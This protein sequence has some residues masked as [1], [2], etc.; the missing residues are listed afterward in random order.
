MAGHTEIKIFTIQELIS[1]FSL[2]NVGKK[3]SIFDKTKLDWV[4]GVYIR[5]SQAIELQDQIIKF[6]DHDFASIMNNWS[7]VQ[8]LDFIDLYK[9]RTKTL[10]ELAQNIIE[11]HS[12]PKLEHDQAQ[13][14]VPDTTLA[15][16]EK[17]IT[18]LEQ[19]SDFSAHSL[20]TYAQLFCREHSIKLPTIAHPIRY[21]LTGK[22]ESP[23]IFHI[24]S[25]L[26]KEESIRRLANFVRVIHETTK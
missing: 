22:K 5:Q 10:K 2:D 24:I 21:A 25:I 6:I 13:S 14:L 11:I 15:I 12:F 9:E 18:S 7:S 8:L 20:S 19:V 23:G 17:F 4:N 1:L 3:G 16:I 26:K